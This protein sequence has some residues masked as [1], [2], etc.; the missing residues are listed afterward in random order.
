[1]I[2]LKEV[3]FVQHIYKYKGVWDL[4]VGLL[5]PDLPLSSLPSNE[6]PLKYSLTSCYAVEFVMH[7]TS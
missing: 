2:Q 1:M 3:D 6:H 7:D 5:S 4:N